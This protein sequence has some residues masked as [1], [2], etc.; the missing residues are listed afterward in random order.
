MTATY[1][2]TQRW[3]YK[4]RQW[5]TRYAGDECQCCGYNIYIGNL[6]FHHIRDKEETICR[7]INATSSWDRILE[8]ADKCVLVCHNCHGE[9]HAGLRMCPEI[10]LDDR[11]IVLAQIISEKPIPKTKQFHNCHCGQKIDKNHKYCSQ[12]CHHDALERT[13]WPDNLPELV[14]QS[15]KCAVALSLGVSDKAVAKRLRNHH[16][17]PVAGIEPAMG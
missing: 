4:A 6:A 11:K 16:Q 8:E 9:I 3:R 7:L 5:I 14:A 10:S 2:S 1:K 17:G 13:Q 12:Q 15:S